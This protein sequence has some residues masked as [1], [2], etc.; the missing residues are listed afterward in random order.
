M[1]TVDQT[2]L[3]RVTQ[4]WT[5]AS[6][7]LKIRVIAPYVL[8]VEGG[9]VRCLAFLPDFGAP[10]GMVVAAITPPEFETDARLIERAREK[11]LFCSFVNPLGWMQYD[12]TGFKKALL[13]WRYFGPVETC[14]AWCG[15]MEAERRE[16]GRA[17]PHTKRCQSRLL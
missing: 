14:P 8:D 13:D 17:E 12:E 6:P 4:S 7:K 1:T 16:C 10:N 11:G 15:R 5:E 2:V 3:D 9:S